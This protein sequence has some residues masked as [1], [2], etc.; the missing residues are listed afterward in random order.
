MA[1]IKEFNADFEQE[2]NFEP[3][4]ISLTDDE[5]KEYQFEI[6]D[7]IEYNDE[8]YLALMPK[9]DDPKEMLD[10]DGELVVLKVIVEGDEEL[11]EEIEDDEE[12]EDVAG[13]FIDRLQDLFDI[14][15]E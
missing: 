4:L 13:I 3:D 1:E 12:Y 9:Y 7:Q 10:S 15:E 6:L 14:T 5:G 11:F 8:H 2:D